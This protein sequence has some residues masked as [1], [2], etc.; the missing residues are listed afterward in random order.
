MDSV[1]DAVE[2]E[3]MEK[4][5]GMTK[6]LLEKAMQKDFRSEDITEMVWEEASAYFDSNKDL[7]ETCKVIE[8][9]VQTY[10]NEKK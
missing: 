7:E 10:L 9:R 1:S 4:S 3:Y 6:I 2:K 8:G 5:I